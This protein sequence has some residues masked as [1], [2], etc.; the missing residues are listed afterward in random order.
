MKLRHDHS[1]KGDVGL[2]EYLQNAKCKGY[3]YESDK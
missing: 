3:K 1:A 2:N